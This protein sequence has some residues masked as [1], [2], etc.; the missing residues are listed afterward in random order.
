M[1]GRLDVIGGW[2]RAF[3]AS[4]LGASVVAC[5]GST[6]ERSSS[7]DA[8]ID[9]SS[10]DASTD[11]AYEGESGLPCPGPGCPPAHPAPYCLPDSGLDCYVNTHCSNGAQTTLTGTVYDPAGRNPLGNVVVF[12]PNDPDPDHLLPIATGASSCVSCTGS[13]RDY[14]TATFTD[15]AGHFV[16][17][18]VPTGEEIPLILQVGKWR[19]A[20]LVPRVMDCATTTLPSSG[21]GQLRLPRNRRE[22]SLPQ[23]A[24]LTGGCDNVA[25]FLQ[26]VGID[27]AEFSAP[28]A[29][30]RVD[31]YQGLGATGAGAALS[32]GVAGDCT[33][34]ACPLWSSK[35]A[36][37]AYDNV[38]LGCECDEHNETKPAPSLQA[39]HDWI[40]EGGQVFATHSQATWFKNGPADLQA[41][42][43][44]TSG[45]ASGA[46]APFTIDTSFPG[47]MNLAAWLANLGDATY[48][49][50]PLDPADVSTSVTTVVGS[51]A[52]AWIRDGSMANVGDGGPTGNVKMLTASMPLPP[53]DAS[54]QGYCGKVNFT[55]IHPG[56]GQALQGVSSD[57]SSAPSPVPG[58]CAVGPLSAGENVL[59][60]LLFDQT[61]CTNGGPIPPPPP[62]TDP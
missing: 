29:G 43:N 16:L 17:T 32:S 45:P 14:V 46:P 3:V 9:S 5:G 10:L 1:W 12:V 52:H 41:I 6:V 38:L 60:Y 11:D 8:S 21:T 15:A 13:V 30:G 59:E 23:M 27:A 24:L 22:G 37:E 39:M 51:T 44:W 4:V 20:T 42:A 26:N 50:V 35:Q 53:A 25:C 55:D 34:P 40:D 2:R 28:G 48:G 49:V 7:P 47:G 31:V 36:L 18:G 62:P 54:P 58:G 57:G 19:R 33:T 56:G 61:T